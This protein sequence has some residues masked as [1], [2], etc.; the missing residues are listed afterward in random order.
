MLWRK[1]E[2]LP[3]KLYVSLTLFYR[4]T[5]DIRYFNKRQCLHNATQRVPLNVRVKSFLCCYHITYADIL[6]KWICV[7]VCLN[8]SNTPSVVHKIR[9]G[10]RELKI[11]ANSVKLIN[12]WTAG[13]CGRWRVD[14]WWIFYQLILWYSSAC[15]ITVIRHISGADL[16]SSGTFLAELHEISQLYGNRI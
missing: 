5:V 4:A 14:E 7:T 8:M 9:S 15:R 6:W 11:L 13:S 10:A 2:R 1:S 3:C 12:L 16:Q